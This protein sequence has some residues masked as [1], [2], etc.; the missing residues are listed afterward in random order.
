VRIQVAVALIASYCCAGTPA[1]QPLQPVTF[2]VG[3]R[4]L[5]TETDRPVAPS[6]APIVKDQRQL[7]LAYAKI[8]DSRGQAG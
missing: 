6:A 8:T 5:I 4:N 1:Q 7:T 3:A 2:T